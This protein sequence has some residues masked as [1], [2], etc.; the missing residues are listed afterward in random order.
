MFD[1]RERELKV[2]IGLPLVV[3]TI[4]ETM[5]YGSLVNSPLWGNLCLCIEY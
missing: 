1:D 5:R 2:R 3:E 4:E